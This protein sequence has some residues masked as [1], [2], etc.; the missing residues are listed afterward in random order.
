MRWRQDVVVVRFA[1]VS[2]VATGSEQDQDK[3]SR[4]EV[5]CKRRDDEHEHEPQRSKHSVNQAHERS[6]TIRKESA[7]LHDQPERDVK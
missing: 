1:A 4:I 6:P 3:C 5:S 2:V 7:T